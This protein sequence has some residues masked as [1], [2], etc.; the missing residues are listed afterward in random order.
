MTDSP[1]FVPEGLVAKPK[2]KWRRLSE[3]VL[4][5]VC[6]ILLEKCELGFEESTY[7]IAANVFNGV[8]L[9][10]FLIRFIVDSADERQPLFVEFLFGY[11]IFVISETDNC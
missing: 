10:L 11:L 4:R 5:P 6:L 3:K 8:K 1:I 7:P 9:A 2:P